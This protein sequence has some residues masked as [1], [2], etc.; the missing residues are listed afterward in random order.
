MLLKE[1]V[2]KNKVFFSD[3]ATKRGLST[4]KKRPF[5]EAL[6]KK[7]KKC[8]TKLGGFGVWPFIKFAN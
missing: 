7:H 4:T 1:A 5:F 6:K 3:P 2:K 8:G